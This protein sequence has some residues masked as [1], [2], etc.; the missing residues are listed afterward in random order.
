M[1]CEAFEQG[2]LARY[3]GAVV[4]HNP[5]DFDNI[6]SY[7]EWLKGWKAMNEEIVLRKYQPG[8]EERSGD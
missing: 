2:R 1:G 8:Q 3:R 6:L 7:R 4:N 5:Y